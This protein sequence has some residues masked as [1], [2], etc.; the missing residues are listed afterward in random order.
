MSSASRTWSSCR[1][2][3]TR[4]SA[5]GGH[6]SRATLRL[7][8]DWARRKNS[9]SSP[10][11]VPPDWQMCIFNYGR[12]EGKSFLLSSALFWLDVSHADGLRVDGVAS[13]LYRDYSR[14][15][16]EWIPNE[17]GGREN[18]EAIAL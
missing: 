12:H 6:R 11:G 2:W 13:M 5:P 7:R 16:G 14:K 18:L 10:L 3:S 9:C 17:Q 4:S 1:S 15:A 8:A